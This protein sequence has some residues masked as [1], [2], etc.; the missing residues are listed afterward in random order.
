MQVRHYRTQGWPGLSD[1]CKWLG[2]VIIHGHKNGY[3]ATRQFSVHGEFITYFC[4]CS[5]IKK[6]TFVIH[7]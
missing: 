4:T 5:L 3:G 7:D 2:L 1:V 6:E